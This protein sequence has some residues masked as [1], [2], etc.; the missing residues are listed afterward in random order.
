MLG[1]MALKA[2]VVHCPRV[3]APRHHASVDPVGALEDG[4]G[5]RAP[6]VELVPL[7]LGP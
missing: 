7:V 5:V 6:P 1:N 4:L 3:R 2:F